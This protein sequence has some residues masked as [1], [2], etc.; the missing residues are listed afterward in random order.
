MK[1]KVITI[2]AFALF[3]FLSAAGQ[4][5]L[6]LENR[7]NPNKRKI[8]D[9]SREYYIKTIDTL[10]R[11]EKIISFNDSSLFITAL[12]NTGRNTTYSYKTKKKDHTYSYPIYKKDTINIPF[13]NLIFMKKIGLKI[14]NG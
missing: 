6:I 11:H 9:T 3:I 2:L 14:E 1:K 7:N 10:F 12:T 13:T 4:Q 8:V 5:I